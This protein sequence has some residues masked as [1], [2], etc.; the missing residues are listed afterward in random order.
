[1]DTVPKEEVVAAHQVVTA[2]VVDTASLVHLLRLALQHQLV[3]VRKVVTAK[4][5]Q[6]TAYAK[7]KSKKYSGY[8][9][10]PHHLML[11]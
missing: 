2:V 1:M 6:T 5:S 11:L 7:L 9:C 4:S 3:L 8:R 10:L